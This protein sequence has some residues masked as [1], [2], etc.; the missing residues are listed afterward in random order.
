[1]KFSAFATASAAPDAATPAAGAGV[2]DAA[3][4]DAACVV[5]AEGAGVA[6]A[7]VVAVDVGEATEVTTEGETTAVRD[8][9]GAA[10]AAH[11]TETFWPPLL[12]E[13]G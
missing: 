8:E 12:M 3:V 13:G 9:L 7:A 5:V 2:A 6:D 4:G 1:V 11:E 10:C